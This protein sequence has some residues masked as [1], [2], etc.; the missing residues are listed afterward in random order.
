MRLS[1]SYSGRNHYHSDQE[2]ERQR[3]FVT[4]PCRVG[5]RRIDGLLDTA[6]EWCVMPPD[7]AHELGLDLDPAFADTRMS[8]RLGLLAGRLERSPLQFYPEQGEVIEVEATWFVSEEW[9]GPPVIGWKGCLERIRFALD[10][11]EE[12]FYFAEL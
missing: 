12:W 4:V 3:L 6:S 7:L 10:P 8:T 9:I 11:G 1:Q 5:T 2:Y